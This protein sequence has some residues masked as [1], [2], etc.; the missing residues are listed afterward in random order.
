[1]PKF[2]T[3]APG[4]WGAKSLR[5]YNYSMVM[6]VDGRVELSGQGGWD[7]KTLEFPTGHTIEA[8]INQAFDNVAFMLDAVGLDWSTRRARQLVSCAGTR[9]HNPDGDRRDGPSV[10]VPDAGA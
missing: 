7:P 5:D 2:K 1:V 9:Q 6:E 4:G 10:Q 3:I 8:E